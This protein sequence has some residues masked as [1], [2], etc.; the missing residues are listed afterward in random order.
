MGSNAVEL[1]ERQKNI[2]SSK[3]DKQTFPDTKYGI[4]VYGDSAKTHLAIKNDLNNEQVKTL[5]EE[6][7][8]LSDG[9]RLNLALTKA[10]GIFMF[11]FHLSF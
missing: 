2:T 3:I 6:L 4:V 10:K 7:V 9:T 11:Y 5:V 8:W 1:F